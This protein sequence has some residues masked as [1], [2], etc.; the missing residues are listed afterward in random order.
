ME[1]V[2][3]VVGNINKVNTNKHVHAYEIENIKVNKFDFII[4]IFFF[5]VLFLV[6]VWGKCT[7][8]ENMKMSIELLKRSARFSSESKEGMGKIIFTL[9]KRGI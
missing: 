9:S 2:Y 3:G 8:I 4:I 5:F 1:W 6:S 7:E